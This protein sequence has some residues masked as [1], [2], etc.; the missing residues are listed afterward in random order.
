VS[1]RLPLKARPVF[2][3]RPRDNRLVFRLPLSRDKPVFRLRPRGNRLVVRLPLLRDKPVFRLRP[4]DKQVSR[5]RLKDKQ[6]SRLRLKDSR[7]VLRSP[8]RVNRPVF[9]PVLLRANR[10][11]PVSL[12]P[13]SKRTTGTICPSLGS[14]GYFSFSVY[15]FI[16]TCRS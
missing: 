12:L 9:R 7:L 6:V 1:L 14:C 8:P 11:R 2:R 10:L 16:T 13:P 3:L 15:L 5:L 4:K